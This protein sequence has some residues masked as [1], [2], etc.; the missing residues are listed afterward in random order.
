MTS[1]LASTQPF[2]K[3]VHSAQKKFTE[4]EDCTSYVIEIESYNISD[5]A[6]HNDTDG[7]IRMGIT[8]TKALKKLEDNCL[9]T[10]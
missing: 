4:K 10:N 3:I 8:F 7:F 9:E 2:I 6:W 5:D 1:N